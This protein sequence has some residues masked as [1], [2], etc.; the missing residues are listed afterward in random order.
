MTVYDLPL[1]WL[2]VWVYHEQDE[3]RNGARLVVVYHAPMYRSFIP[4]ILLSLGFGLLLT[5]PSTALAAATIS[6][7]P[8]TA[9]LKTGELWST[10]AQVNATEPVNSADLSVTFPADK[11]EA[12]NVDTGSTVFGIVLFPPAIDNAA[13]TIRFRQT[14]PS[15]FSGN[16]GKLGTITFKAKA[17]GTAIVGVAPGAKIIANDGKGTNVF[18]SNA[19]ATL[20]IVTPPPPPSKAPTIS[21]SS[22]PDQTA[23]YKNRTVAYSWSGGMQ[24]YNFTV[25]QSPNTELATQS[26]GTMTTASTTLAADGVWYAHVRGLGGSGWSPTAHFRFQVD[27]TPPAQFSAEVTPKGEIT[28]LPFI[29]FFTTDITSGIGYYDVKVDQ[30]EPVRS[31]NPYK[32]QRIGPGEHKVVVRAFDKA[33]NSV[34]SRTG[35]VIKPLETPKIV[36]PSNNA[37]FLLGDQLKVLGLA[38]ANVKIEIFLNNNKVDEVTTDDKGNFSTSKSLFLF[39]GKYQ[40][41]AKAVNGDGI[42]SAPSES[43]NVL[44]DAKAVK[45]FGAVW[46]GWVIFG[47]GSLLIIGLTVSIGLLL[48]KLWRINRRWWAKVHRF[49]RELDQDL[50]I[51]ESSVDAS[52]DQVYASQPDKSGGETIKGTVHREVKRVEHDL[53]EATHEEDETAQMSD[54]SQNPTPAAEAAITEQQALD[55]PEALDV[56]ETPLTAAAPTAPVSSLPA[57]PETKS[58]E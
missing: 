11:L 12:T 39:P 45:L 32:V 33:G 30:E 24:G 31:E 53:D 19:N 54:M 5:F 48:V 56:G 41:T 4:L 9:T 26:V 15:P 27:A 28:V 6:F 55:G 17:T 8:A 22:N 40:V 38:A 44:I 58:A 36:E 47:G 34:E 42:E 16:G 23:W 49:N 51:L 50:N 2:A 43:I 13:G 37:L 7:T 14:S 29:T 20:T 52:V 21:S 35:F 18:T 57:P 10:M 46:P 1:C 25:D 3:C